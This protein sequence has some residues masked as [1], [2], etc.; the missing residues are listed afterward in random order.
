MRI[1]I[2]RT[3]KGASFIGWRFCDFYVSTSH[4]TAAYFLCRRERKRERKEFHY[5]NLLITTDY[6]GKVL[7]NV[8][9]FFHLPFVLRCGVREL[10]IL[11]EFGKMGM[12]VQL[13]VILLTPKGE[14]E[15]NST[16]G[17]FLLSF[18]FSF[19]LSWEGKIHFI[20]EDRPKEAFLHK[21]AENERV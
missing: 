19:L 1:N 5:W 7:E 11:R 6:R 8:F 4:I 21:E 20:T 16:H 13:Y 2:W 9:S 12:P 10:W 14:K 15:E 17:I 3:K 18:L